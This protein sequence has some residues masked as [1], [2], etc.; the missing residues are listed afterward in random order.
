MPAQATLGVTL[1]GRHHRHGYAT[2]ALSTLLDYV[3]GTMKL[4]RVI[5]DTDPEN[6]SSWRL[7]ERLGMRR[8]THSIQSLW[9][10]GRWANEYVYAILAEEWL[11]APRAECR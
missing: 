6:T 10:K 8:E 7:L 4:H 1:A 5:A 9:F 11:A 2:E 3:F